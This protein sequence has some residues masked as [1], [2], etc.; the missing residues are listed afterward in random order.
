MT[1]HAIT[2]QATLTRERGMTAGRTQ[3]PPQPRRIAAPSASRA[4][5]ADPARQQAGRQ[6][7]GA[8]S[9]GLVLAARGAWPRSKR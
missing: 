8:G 6:P 3:G 9:G 4:L 5:L 1:K 2:S 7:A